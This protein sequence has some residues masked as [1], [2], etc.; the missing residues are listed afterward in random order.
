MQY[1]RMKMKVI[2]KE[3]LAKP[4]VNFRQ[5]IKMSME[6]RTGNDIN[7]RR[8]DSLISQDSDNEA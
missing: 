2:Y 1:N 8:E 5:Y 7:G 4:G 3:Q 6:I